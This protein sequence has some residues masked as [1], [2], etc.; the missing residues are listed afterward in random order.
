MKPIPDFP[1]LLATLDGRIWEIKRNY[2]DGG[3]FLKQYANTNG[4]M[5]VKFTHNG[6]RHTRQ[7]HR[8]IL[9][10]FMGSCPPGMVGKHRSG[11]LSDNRLENICW[12]KKG[13][14]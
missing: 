6:H 4:S 7:V 9:E 11:N 2:L 12:G 5:Y 14:K 10:A 3:K 1:S 8:L 13:I